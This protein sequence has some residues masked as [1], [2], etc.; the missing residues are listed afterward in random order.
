MPAVIEISLGDN[1]FILITPLLAYL[2]NI[3][4]FSAVHLLLMISPFLELENINS[5]CFL[6][7]VVTRYPWREADYIFRLFYFG[8]E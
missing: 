2:K 8:Q 5:I 1:Y 6:Q 7:V 4:L 3:A